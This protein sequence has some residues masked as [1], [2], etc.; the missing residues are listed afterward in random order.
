MTSL[1]SSLHKYYILW[2]YNILEGLTAFDACS[3]FM[4]LAAE[5]LKLKENCDDKFNYRKKELYWQH[6]F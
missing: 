3:G 4:F 6:K 1:F 2:K 5:M